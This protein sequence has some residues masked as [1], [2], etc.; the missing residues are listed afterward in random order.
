MLEIRINRKTVTLPPSAKS[1]VALVNPHL[2]YDSILG[3]T[4]SFPEIPIYPE[5]QKIFGYVENPAVTGKLAEYWAEQFLDGH[6]I[7]AGYY[8]LTDTNGAYKGTFTDRLG[9]FFGDLQKTLLT[10]LDMGSYAVPSMPANGEGTLEGSWAYCF[11]SIVNPD[12]FGT[13]GASIS[14]AGQVNRYDTSSYNAAAPKV[15][16]FSLKWVIAKIASLT[17]V[18]ITGSLLTHPAWSRLV[19][20]N[21]R[22]MEGTDFKPA[23]HMP[24][25][26]IEDFF[27]ELRKLLNL[28][29]T[30]DNSAKSLKIDLWDGDLTLG[31]VAD[32]SDKAS[33]RGLSI[34]ESNQRIQ[35][36]YELDGGDQLM[37]DKPSDLADYTTPGVGNFARNTSKFSTLLVDSGT[38]FAQARQQ[39]AT[40]QFGQLASK[41]TPRLLFWH[42]FTS[43]K[44]RAL[45]SYTDGTLG[46]FSLFWNGTNGLK[47]RCWSNYEAMRA[48]MFFVPQKFVLN[49]TD[50]A[51]LDFSR[52][53]HFN[54][55]NYYV[56]SIN[57]DVP[58]TAAADCLLLKAL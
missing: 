31:P 45:P 11:P 15:P 37:K 53:I 10:E 16:M 50:L 42:G 24:E 7:K 30:L 52:K 58:I 32:W 6:L 2:V 5:N 21:V 34:P 43:S 57:A 39:G 54:G 12:F 23:R 19:L 56:V 17:G 44:P 46:T 27:V 47:A 26:N 4:S 33:G 8:Y 25:L 18:S 13:N 40:T 28:K 36:A 48:G 35:L 20:Y 38:N 9:L 1:S 51:Q 55:L 29:Y 14:Y 22:V 49:A 3:S 41:A